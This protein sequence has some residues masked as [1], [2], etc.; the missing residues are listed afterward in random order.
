MEEHLHQIL[1]HAHS[2]QFDVL[3]K[4]FLLTFLTSKLVFCWL[5]SNI[6]VSYSQ[7]EADHV[8]A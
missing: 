4:N 3:S 1:F 5:Q 6:S 8:E 2:L 7:Q